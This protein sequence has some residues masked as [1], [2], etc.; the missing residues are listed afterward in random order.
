[1]LQ[2]NTG[3]TCRE[4]KSTSVELLLSRHLYRL[5]EQH[6]KPKPDTGYHR[7]AQALGGYPMN[8]S[9]AVT[10]A[11]NVKHEI[12]GESSIV[13]VIPIHWSVKISSSVM[14]FSVFY[15]LPRS[16]LVFYIFFFNIA[17]RYKITG[18]EIN[19]KKS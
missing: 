11:C 10:Q 16:I 19:K 8:L 3:K 4:N 18:Y 13:N 14:N 7:L 5:E 2:L 1:M 9:Y 15:M 12:S 6:T 17:N